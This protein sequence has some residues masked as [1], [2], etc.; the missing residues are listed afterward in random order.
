[1]YITTEKSSD[2]K[3]RLQLIHGCL[4]LFY[5]ELLKMKTVFFKM[6]LFCLY[7]KIRS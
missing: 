5:L 1:M 4:D 3:I 6:F 2:K 7:L